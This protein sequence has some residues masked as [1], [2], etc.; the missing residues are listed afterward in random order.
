MMEV[1]DLPLRQLANGSGPRCRGRARQPRGGRSIAARRR[2]SL[3][4]AEI[5]ILFAFIIFL[6]DWSTCR[7]V[8]SWGPADALGRPL[9]SVLFP[10]LSSFA[11][12]GAR[13]MATPSSPTAGTGLA[14]ILSAP[15][16]TCSA[17][18]PVYR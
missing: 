8:R 12:R 18:L 1:I 2:N 3:P 14:T 17:R 5:L 10:M 15:L 13:I 6:E 7:G 16:R 9:R 11:L 4:S